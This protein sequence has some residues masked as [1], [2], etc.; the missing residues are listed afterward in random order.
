MSEA[1]K[2]VSTEYTT[3]YVA[4]FAPRLVSPPKELA[5]GKTRSNQPSPALDLEPEVDCLETNHHDAKYEE[6]N[7]NLYTNLLQPLAQ[8]VVLV[9]NVASGT[10]PYNQN[11]NGPYDGCPRGRG[12]FFVVKEGKTIQFVAKRNEERRSHCG[13]AGAK[14]PQLDVLR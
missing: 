10:A 8:F 9:P 12:F 13:E 14:N 7:A 4:R 5:R 2:R 3:I 11:A 6:E 1:T